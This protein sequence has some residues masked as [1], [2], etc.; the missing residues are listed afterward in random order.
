MYHANVN[1]DFMKENVIQI[2]GK[3]MI[4]I[5]VSV[6]NAMCVKRLCLQSFYM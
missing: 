4:N 1:V 3:I 6:K 5:D 2:N